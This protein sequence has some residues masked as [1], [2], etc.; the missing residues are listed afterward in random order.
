MVRAEC[1]AEPVYVVFTVHCCSRMS[2]A[3]PGNTAAAAC[4]ECVLYESCFLELFA[5]RVLCLY[6]KKCCCCRRVIRHP[7][8]P[9]MLSARVCCAA[10]AYHKRDGVCHMYAA[11]RRSLWGG[12]ALEGPLCYRS[13]RPFHTICDR[14]TTSVVNKGAS[15]STIFGVLTSAMCKWQRPFRVTGSHV[16]SSQCKINAFFFFFQCAE[17]CLHEVECLR[18]HLLMLPVHAS[19]SSLGKSE[20]VHYFIWRQLNFEWGHLHHH[21]WLCSKRAHFLPLALLMAKRSCLCVLFWHIISSGS[22]IAIIEENRFASFFY[23][24]TS[25]CQETSIPKFILSLHTK[26]KMLFSCTYL[27]L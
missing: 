1:I 11:C 9:W 27:Y 3:L 12:V 22:F 13:G 23:S 10:C 26:V 18:I 21:L 7:A 16:K 20:L 17:L 24:F 8:V 6:K 15:V 2:S 5:S 25:Q 14:T 19:S 4:W